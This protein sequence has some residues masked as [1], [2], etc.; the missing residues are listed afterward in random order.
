[1]KLLPFET[2]PRHTPRRFVP[3]Q[4]DLGDWRQIEPLY[5]QLDAR[6]PLCASVA[7][8]EQ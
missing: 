4:I 7:E 8:F 5:D 1:M 2:L 6:A 3:A